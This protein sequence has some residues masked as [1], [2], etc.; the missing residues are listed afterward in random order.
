MPNVYIASDHRGFHLKEKLRSVFPTFLDLGPTSYDPED[1]FNDA[2]S[3]VAQK[4]KREKDALGVLICGSAIGISIAANR[5]RG[6][7][8]AVVRDLE[9]A[10]SSRQHLDANII[11]L[12]ADSVENAKDPLESEKALEDAVSLVETF[13]S[14]PF[15]GKK[16]YLR[17]IKRLDKER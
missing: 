2:A 3:A 8:A 17:R 12:S 16:K 11:C 4:L 15:S 14:T 6:V 9:T 5:H 1:D 13:L 10:V 7:R